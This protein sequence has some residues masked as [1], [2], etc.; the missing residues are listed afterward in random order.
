MLWELWKEVTSMRAPF[1]RGSLIGIDPSYTRT[2]VCIYKGSGFS[3]YRIDSI[4][5]L[6]KSFDSLFTESCKRARLISSL[7][8]KEGGSLGGFI[9]EAPP[10]T[11]QFSGDI[12]I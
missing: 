10:P 12:E 6:H 9:I 2:G 4:D 8:R 5:L 3:F 1:S 11:S 7:I